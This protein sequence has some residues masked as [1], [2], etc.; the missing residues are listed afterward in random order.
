MVVLVV[1]TEVFDVCY[2]IAKAPWQ[3]WSSR[4]SYGFYRALGSLICVARWKR[5]GRFCES[6]QR[7]DVVFGFVLTF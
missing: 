7:I 4:C 2:G 6:A 1:C 3:Q 5:H